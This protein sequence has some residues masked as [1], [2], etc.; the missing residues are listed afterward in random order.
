MFEVGLGDTHRDL[1]RSITASAKPENF[2]SARLQH[3]GPF[4]RL[5]RDSISAGESGGNK[6]NA[7][8]IP[9]AR[10]MPSGLGTV[11]FLELKISWHGLC[12]SVW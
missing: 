12:K 9:N 8:G 3:V 4:A 5:K 10:L 11:K 2:V 1:I 7:H 6:A